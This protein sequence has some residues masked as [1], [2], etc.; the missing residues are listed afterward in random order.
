[1]TRISKIQKILITLVGRGSAG[2]EPL[3]KTGSCPVG[4]LLRRVMP[5]RAC[6]RLYRGEE[7]RL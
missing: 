2:K 4:V 1:M 6:I 5:S 3:G 7:G